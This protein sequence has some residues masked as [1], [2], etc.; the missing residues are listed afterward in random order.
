MRGADC[1]VPRKEMARE[2]RWRKFLVNMVVAMLLSEMFSGDVGL[3]A[4]GD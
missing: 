3:G 4:D 1:T 2:D